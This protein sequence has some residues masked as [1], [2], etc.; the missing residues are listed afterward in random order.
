MQIKGGYMKHDIM[1]KDER[2]HC[3]FGRY[4]DTN[5][6]SLQL[7]DDEGFPYMIPSFNADFDPLKPMMV[8][9][10]WSENEGIE[11]VLID[12]GII[13]KCVGTIQQG[14]IEANLYEVNKE[15]VP[16]WSTCHY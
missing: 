5:L 10:N 1:F 2:L 14:F 15:Y 8:V 16:D 12:S 7:Y 9:K 13:T 6:I 4:K 3:E 11:Q